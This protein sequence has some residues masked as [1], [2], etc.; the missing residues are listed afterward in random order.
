MKNLITSFLILSTFI[1]FGQGNFIAP[2]TGYSIK[3][4]SIIN[5]R[6]GEQLRGQVKH[7]KF[8]GMF[9]SDITIKVNGEKRKIN[10]KEISNMY[11]AQNALSKIVIEKDQSLEITSLTKD[12]HFGNEGNVYTIEG[13][14]YYESQEV[15]FSRNKKSYVMLI[16]LNPGFCEKIR[17]Y[18]ILNSGKKKESLLTINK[19]TLDVDFIPMVKSNRYM[20]KKKDE[21][22]EELTVRDFVNE[23]Y[24]LFDNC[25]EA[26]GEGNF[27]WLKLDKH[28]FNYTT[29]CN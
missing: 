27:H 22:V 26:K 20:I 19:K 16:L 5:L 8:K 17:V 6:N 29:K 11:L 9:I 13:Y 14:T 25:E 23:Y 7:N 12:K 4:T 28:I 10:A 18:N 21:E 2:V 1:A 3:K 24:E 15:T